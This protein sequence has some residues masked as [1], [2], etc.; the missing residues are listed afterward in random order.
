[1]REVQNRKQQLTSVRDVKVL[2]AKL[3]ESQLFASVVL[4]DPRLENDLG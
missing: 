4:V 1:M 2:E 3:F